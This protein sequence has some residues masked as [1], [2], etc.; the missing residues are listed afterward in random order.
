MKAKA[1]KAS[2]KTSEVRDEEKSTIDKKKRKD[3]SSLTTDEFLE[4]D[5][6][7]ESNSNS[8]EENGDISTISMF[9]LIS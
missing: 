3:L 1:Q 9:L 6:E 4:Q 7:D 2:V 5:F 8:D